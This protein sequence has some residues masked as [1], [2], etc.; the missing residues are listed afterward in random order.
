MAC[1]ETVLNYCA[2]CQQINTETVFN[3]RWLNFGFC[4]LK[5]LNKFQNEIAP[6]CNIC[7]EFLDYDRIY[8]RDD[9]KIS[10][11]LTFICADCFFARSGLSVNCYLCSKICYIGYGT[12]KLTTSGLI[13]KYLCASDCDG[14]DGNKRKS[15]MTMET[16]AK[17]GIHGKCAKISC[18]GHEYGIC[19]A[20]CLTQFG[21]DN[22]TQFGNFLD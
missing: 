13:P 18:N 5:C 2:Q 16:C 11:V 3:C 9:A 1:A 15:S 12:L 8:L 21:K 19:T 14:S 20:V 4:N 17:C 7:E 6:E 10:S 22:S